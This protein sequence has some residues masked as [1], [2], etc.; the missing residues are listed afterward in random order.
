LL[1]LQQER[2][3]T[4]P[5]VQE[6]APKQIA[7]VIPVS[8]SILEPTVPPFNLD[9]ASRNPPEQAIP[10]V[11]LSDDDTIPYN[12][13]F[14]PYDPVEEPRL[15]SPPQHNNPEIINLEPPEIIDLRSQSPINYNNEINLEPLDPDTEYQRNI[16]RMFIT[17]D[18]YARNTYLNTYN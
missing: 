11:D 7:R 2:G 14:N 12:E 8:H 16:H 15:E 4:D 3:I 10:I 9:S 17:L 13:F 18:E 1:R 6:V 5:I